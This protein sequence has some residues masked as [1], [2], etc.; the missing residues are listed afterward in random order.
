[1]SKVDP[2]LGNRVR[3]L[4]R[5]IARSRPGKAIE[6]RIPPYAAVQLGTEGTTTTHR[7]GTPPSVVE[8]DPDTFLALVDGRLSWNDALSSHRIQASGAHCDLS[9]LFHLSLADS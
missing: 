1:M 3:H 2:D 4:A 8:M 9:D 6:L 5:T 7:R